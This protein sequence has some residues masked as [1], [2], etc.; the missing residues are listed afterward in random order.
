MRKDNSQRGYAFLIIAIAV[1]I[2]AM[3][4]ITVLADFAIKR[5]Q[6]Q[7]DTTRL[8]AVYRAIV[9]DPSRDTFGYLGDVGAYPT[10]FQ[11]LVVAPTGATG[12]NG[13]YLTDTFFNGSTVN[14]TY[15]SPMEYDLSLVAGS[16]D[17]LAI[18]S[19]GPDH[20]SSNTASNPND[21]TQFT[22]A[23]PSSGSTYTTA[24]GNADNVA[25]PD[26]SVSPS[27][28]LQYTPSGTL[29]YNIVNKDVNQANAIV[30]A[31]P[32]MYAFTATAHSRPSDSTTVFWNTGQVNNFVQGLWNVSINSFNNP[33][34]FQLLSPY[35]SESVGV[36]PRRTVQHTIRVE[37]INSGTTPI[38]NLTVY[39]NTAT[40]MD[41]LRYPFSGGGAKLY[42]KLNPGSNTG[43][44]SG[45]NACTSVEAVDSATGTVVLA[46][47]TT[48]WGTS[49]VH[50][51]SSPR[52][53]FALTNGN[54]TNGHAA[55]AT[56]EMMQVASIN[57][58]VL[59][60]GTVYQRQQVVFNNIDKGATIYVYDQAG[61][62]G[63][64]LGS[65]VIAGATTQT[66]Y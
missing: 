50:Y 25:Y 23:R 53:T 41:I 46:A 48:P 12:W 5:E 6:R 57:D 47:W 38:F 62:F 9:G 14:D 37:D 66:I 39:N 56:H 34:G 22:G 32:G 33:S 7:T 20:S 11:D 4:G 43:S 65:F 21:Q 3:L 60:L 51:V 61:Q 16:P 31:C 52:Y 64:L 59:T 40:Q 8:A 27:T 17:E 2:V 63:T 1:F 35:F 18:I 36:Y 29:I 24:G 45:I 26:Y 58:G 44:M 10:T 13:P 49:S 28:A 30:P 42:T 55:V 19:R 54:G 15:G